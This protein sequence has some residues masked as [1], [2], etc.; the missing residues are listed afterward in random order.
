[1]VLRNRPPHLFSRPNGLCGAFRGKI[2]TDKNFALFCLKR[3]RNCFSEKH[4]SCSFLRNRRLTYFRGKTD[5]VECFKVK[6][7]W[8]RSLLP[9]TVPKSF[10]E[11]HVSSLFLRNPLSPIFGAR[12][13]MWHAS[14]QNCHGRKLCS[15]L[16]KPALKWFFRKT[17]FQSLFTK[18][19]LTYFQGQ[20]DYMTHFE[21]KL[22]RMRTSLAF[23]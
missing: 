22:S 21:A 12:Q 15:L 8:I 19:P 18:P 6:L 1:M 10:S 16:P 4:V 23:V 17:C 7:S 20:K 5:N 11:K 9:K 3:P 2:V 13:T 14:R